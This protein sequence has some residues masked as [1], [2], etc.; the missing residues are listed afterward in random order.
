[1]A[2]P[3]DPIMQNA[4]SLDL[5]PRFQQTTV[6][7]GSPATNEEKVIA[8]LLVG[9]NSAIISG[10]RVHGFAAFTV[11]TSG[12]SATMRIRQASVTGSVVVTSGATTVVA[13]NLG[14]AAVHG[15]DTAAVLPNQTYVLTLQ[16]GSG[17][18]ISTVSA[19]MLWA[20]V[21]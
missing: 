3:A 21:V 5:S 11:G 20:E 13:A 12:V 15:F 6:V 1:M 17:G 2:N 10:I 18:A 7:A 19:L 14:T 9:T 8:T 4:H 16:I